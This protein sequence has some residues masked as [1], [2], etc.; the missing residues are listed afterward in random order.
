M[1]KILFAGRYMRI[2]WKGNALVYFALQRE[3]AWME[4]GRRPLS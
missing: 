4:V 2:V 3:G 1:S